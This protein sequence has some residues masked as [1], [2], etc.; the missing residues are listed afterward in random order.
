MTGFAAGSRSRGDPGGDHRAVGQDRRAG[1]QRRSPR[2]R[3]SARPGKVLE[4][5]RVARRVRQARR[6]RPERGRKPG[7]IGLRPDQRE[8]AARDLGRVAQIFETLAGAALT[9]L[10]PLVTLSRNAGEGGPGR[11]A[12]WVRGG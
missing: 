4:D 3:R 8:G 1:G 2:R 11:E 7:E 10:A 6:Q 12:G 9:R 5:R